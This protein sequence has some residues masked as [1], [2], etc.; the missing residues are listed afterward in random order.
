MG[1]KMKLLLIMT[2]SVLATTSCAKPE[3]QFLP[4]VPEPLVMVAEV[5]R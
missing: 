2:I 3:Y 1:S 5:E 4:D